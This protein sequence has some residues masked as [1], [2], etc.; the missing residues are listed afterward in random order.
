MTS[1]SISD[2]LASSKTYEEF[3]LKVTDSELVEMMLESDKYYMS[4]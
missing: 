1:K 2:K 3:L 4:K